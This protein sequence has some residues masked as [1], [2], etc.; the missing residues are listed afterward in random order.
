VAP[1]RETT[2]RGPA[3]PPPSVSPRSAPTQNSGAAAVAGRPA[4]PASAYARAPTLIGV[5][6]SRSGDGAPARAPEDASITA[7]RAPEDAS[8]TAV[9]PAPQETRAPGASFTLPANPLSE[10]GPDDLASFIDCTLFEA[11]TDD[12]EAVVVDDAG[13]TVEI[14]PLAPAR[15]FVIPGPS[16]EELLSPTLPPAAAKKGATSADLKARARQ[17]ARRYGVA[18]GFAAG[19]LLIGLAIRRPGHRSPAA[20]AAPPPAARVAEAPPAP[21]APAAPEIRPGSPAA[22]A[23]AAPP[24]PKPA[25]AP[26]AEEQ[27]AKIA[28]ARNAEEQAAKTAP[29]PKAPEAEEASEDKPAE[30]PAAVAKVA[31]RAAPAGATGEGSCVVRVVTEPSDARVLWGDKAIGVT[32]IDA[33][34]VPCGA[35]SVTFRRD[36]YQPVTRDLVA[37]ADETT[38]VSQKLHRPTATL[39]VGSSPPHAEITVNG[40]G[41]GFTPKRISVSRFES[42][43]IRV[44]LAGYAP[45]KKSVYVR[46]AE[47]RLGTT[48]VRAEGKRAG[49]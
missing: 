41:Q 26:K 3:P 17:L 33:A 10:L 4:P 39:V 21:P 45:W 46:E 44:S 43:S 8:I 11:N 30:K 15:P 42:V 37:R 18:A 19:A 27:A 28:P 16:V 9:A 35:A 14:D 5:P 7:A 29:A 31:K 24:A 12:A 1:A 25:P 23:V 40:Q 38:D 20:P 6:S 36:R 47:T 48:L 2:A 32:P 34:R 49:R 13:P 22:E